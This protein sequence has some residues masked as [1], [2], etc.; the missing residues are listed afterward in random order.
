M[1]P[2][3]ALGIP[4]PSESALARTRTRLHFA[5]DTGESPPIRR[6]RHSWSRRARAHDGDRSIESRASAGLLPVA[7]CESDGVRVFEPRRGATSRRPTS[8]LCT[9]I[10]PSRRAALLLVVR[11]ERLV[12]WDGDA[13]FHRERMRCSESS[14]SRGA[15]GA[16]AVRARQGS[17]RAASSAARAHAAQRSSFQSP[18]RTSVRYVSGWPIAKIAAAASSTVN[19]RRSAPAS[20]SSRAA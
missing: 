15:F 3:V 9:A 11:C 20:A 18:S 17:M 13:R 6:Q 5:A 1:S 2:A 19:P 16:R 8:C 12:R 4:D 14:T 10:A 7:H